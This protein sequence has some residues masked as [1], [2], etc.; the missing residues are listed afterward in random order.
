MQDEKRFIS[1][2][3][4]LLHYYI[5][6]RSY[7]LGR[8]SAQPSLGLLA[9]RVSLRLVFVAAALAAAGFVLSCLSDWLCPGSMRDCRDSLQCLPSTY[10]IKTQ[11]L[12]QVWQNFIEIIMGFEHIC[13]IK[14]NVPNLTEEP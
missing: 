5:T 14:S 11:C 2:K 6:L 8:R 9:C 1:A 13:L 3:S 10:T 12:R 7:L 4:E